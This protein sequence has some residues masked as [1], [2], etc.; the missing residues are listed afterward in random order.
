MK[1]LKLDER[2]YPIPYFV[3]IVNGKPDFRYQDKK[4][5][6]ACLNHKKCSVCGNPLL[7]A[8]F[9]FISGPMGLA[10]RTVSD[11]PMHEECA[12]FSLQACPHLYFEKAERRSEDQGGPQAELIRKKPETVVLMKADKY[13]LM[14]DGVHIRFRLVLFE[15][16]RYEENKLVMVDFHGRQHML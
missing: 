6:D 12:R 11:A 13:E 2:G 7:A 16:Y 8:S 14:A 1:N 3:P 5:R 9:W 4:K 10:N 15:V